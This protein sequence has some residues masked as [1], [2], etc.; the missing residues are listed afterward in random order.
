[1]RLGGDIMQAEVFQG[2]L[3][4]F[5]GTMFGSACVLF[6]KSRLN[7]MLQNDRVCGGSHGG[8]CAFRRCEISGRGADH[9]CGGKGESGCLSI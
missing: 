2:I 9:T 5:L 4:L 8:G 1:M 6:M 7:P 3:I